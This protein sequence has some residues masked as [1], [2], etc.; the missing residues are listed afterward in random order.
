MIAAE[1]QMAGCPVAGYARGGLVE[2]VEDGVSGFL[3]E[4]DD[5]TALAAAARASL[6]LDRAAVRK[7]ALQ[8]LS[9]DASLDAYET[10]LAA[11]AG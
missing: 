9:L 11:V 2:A 5:V 6:T 3:A 4:P 8:R 7:S 1:A 10:A